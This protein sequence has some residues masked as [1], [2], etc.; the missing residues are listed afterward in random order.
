MISIL[1]SL[2]QS[3]PWRL[4]QLTM[5]I[6]VFLLCNNTYADE[7]ILSQEV[8]IQE[9]FDAQTPELSVLWVTKTIGER[10]EKI[11]GHKP[12]QLRQRYWKGANKTAWVL[13]EIGKEEPISA[14]FVVENGKIVSARVL[15]YRE[16]R[17]GEIKY[18]VFLKQYVGAQLNNSGVLSRNIDGIS[19]A[20]LSVNAM[21]RMARVA[22][23]M[24]DLSKEPA[25]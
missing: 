1:K 5:I 23:L 17:G 6:W 12:A 7:Q 8:F 18:P 13:D 2:F 20:T 3:K 9:A 24:D 11:L 16:S 25:K 14:G 21:S 4:L 15:V 19:G 22:L 10:I